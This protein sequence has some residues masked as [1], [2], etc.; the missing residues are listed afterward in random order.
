MAEPGDT[1]LTVHVPVAFRRRR[2]RKAM[3]TADRGTVVPRAQ[4]RGAEPSAIIRALA[5][6]FRWRRLIETGVHTTVH[7]IA[8][9]ER[10][11]PSYVS[12]VLRL[13]L[14]AP[15]VVEALMEAQSTD[16]GPLLVHLMKPFKVEWRS[17]STLN[18]Q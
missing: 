4:S 2:S 13:T 3:V 7:D 16:V 9:E 11:N 15:E 18:G 17:Q 14:L 6:A 1:T 8:K 10:I 12:R 5:R